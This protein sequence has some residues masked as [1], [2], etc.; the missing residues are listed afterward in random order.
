MIAA[1]TSSMI[2][3]I[4]GEAGKDVEQI[5]LVLE[6]EELILPP[7]VLSELL[8]DHALP[9]EIANTLMLL[10]RAS[11][12]EGYWE[13]VGFL[14]ASILKQKRKARLADS[15]IAQCCID[16]N[17]SII[18]RDKDFKNFAKYTNLKIFLP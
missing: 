2:A 5:T 10:P 4:Q 15:L 18:T 11:I 17:Y 7:P 12:K 3:Y 16:H 13:R 9:Q 8:S 1:D 6:K 14:R